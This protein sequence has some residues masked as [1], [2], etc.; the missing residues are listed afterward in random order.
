MIARPEIT[1]SHRKKSERGPG[2]IPALFLVLT[3]RF[4]VKKYLE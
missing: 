4:Q 3:F 1:T 2:Q